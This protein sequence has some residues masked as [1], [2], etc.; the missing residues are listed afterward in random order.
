VSA[1]GA[2]VFDE[3][4]VEGLVSVGVAEEEA[5]FFGGVVDFARAREAAAGQEFQV[6][7]VGG[8]VF[9]EAVIVAGKDDAEVEGLKRV[10]QV[11]PASHRVGHAGVEREMGEENRGRVGVERLRG[12]KRELLRIGR[13][14]QVFPSGAVGGIECEELPAFVGKGV[15][16]AIRK[17]LE[18]VGKA[19]GARPDGAIGR[20]IVVAGDGEVRH[21]EKVERFF[22]GGEFSI[23]AGLCEIT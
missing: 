18:I 10:E 7:L 4:V 3:F 12:V 16:A 19:G 8:E 9:G 15:V 5:A 13:Q 21:A 23:G 11:V 2:A 14:R 17:E 1:S 20:A 22:R 6:R